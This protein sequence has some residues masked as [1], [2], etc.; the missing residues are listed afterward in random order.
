MH[1]SRPNVQRKI[2]AVQVQG[3]RGVVVG[4]LN[5]LRVHLVGPL[6]GNELRDLLDRID[7]GVLEIALLHFCE[8]DV[9][10]NSGDR[11]RRLVS[12]T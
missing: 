2:V 4:G 3:D 1:P 11:R 8:P 7:I 6:C 5:D 9:S 12:S 10:R